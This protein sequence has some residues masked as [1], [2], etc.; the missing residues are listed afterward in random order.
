MPRLSAVSVSLDPFK[1]GKGLARV[2]LDRSLCAA[3]FFRAFGRRAFAARQ[4]VNRRLITA[5]R[6]AA[7]TVDQFDQPGKVG[8]QVTG[9]FARI[10]FAGGG[11]IVRI[12]S[13]EALGTYLRAKSRP[14]YEKIIH[15]IHS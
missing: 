4:A 15:M 10:C 9:R 7:E 5:G 8:K 11:G 14:C 2:F 1:Y 3:L 13:A 12:R 6:L